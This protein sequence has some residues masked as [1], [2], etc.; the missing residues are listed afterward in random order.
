MAMPVQI[1]GPDER[2]VA[3]VPTEAET[4]PKNQ[5]PAGARSGVRGERATSRRS[6]A[7]ETV[8]LRD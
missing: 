8:D 7:M 5:I 4:A 6:G 3:R 2:L 1:V